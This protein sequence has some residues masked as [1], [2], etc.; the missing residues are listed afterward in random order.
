MSLKKQVR[1][2][3]GLQTLALWAEILPPWLR[4]DLNAS[5]V[6]GHLEEREADFQQVNLL[7][8]THFFLGA[9]RFLRARDDLSS[10]LPAYFRIH[11]ELSLEATRDWSLQDLLGQAHV[12]LFFPTTPLDLLGLSPGTPRAIHESYW[13]VTLGYGMARRLRGHGPWETRPVLGLGVSW[14]QPLPVE[15]GEI[16]SLVIGNTASDSRKARARGRGGDELAFPIF[17]VRWQVRWEASWGSPLRFSWRR[18]FT[19]FV[20]FELKV[21][22]GM[23]LYAVLAYADGRLPLS[24]EGTSE[25]RTGLELSM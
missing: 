16:A 4:A 19:S 20:E 1:L 24:Q 13:S 22:L 25:I 21:P 8:G 18:D 12:S 9:R 15:F 10:L 23:G 6:F 7:L 17:R 14:V 11:G 3:L 5:L 2:G